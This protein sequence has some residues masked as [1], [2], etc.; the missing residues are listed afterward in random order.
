VSTSRPVAFPMAMMAGVLVAAILW[1]LPAPAVARGRLVQVPHATYTLPV[2]NGVWSFT[3]R[4]AHRN[5]LVPPLVLYDAHPANLDCSAI[6]FDYRVSQLAANEKAIGTVRLR[7]RCKHVPVGARISLR[8]RD[9]IVR[10]VPIR[11][12]TGRVAFSLDKPPGRVRPLV[13]LRAERIGGRC[14]TRGARLRIR[15]LRLDFA[16]GVTCER[17]TRRSTAVLMIGGLLRSSST[18]GTSLTR[19][20]AATPPVRATRE[21]VG[22]TPIDCGLGQ[23]VVTVTCS[24]SLDMW[25]WRS[26]SESFTFAGCP[27]GYHYTPGAYPGWLWSVVPDNGSWSV[28]DFAGDWWVTNWSWTHRTLNLT[29]YCGLSAP[30][31][32]TPPT[33]VG[34]AV[35]GRTLSCTNGTW[36]GYPNRFDDYEWTNGQGDEVALGQQYT[37]TSADYNGPLQCWVRAHNAVGSTP[38][39]SAYSPTVVNG[40]PY[41]I[42]DTSP[43]MD[44][45]DGSSYSLPVPG[46]GQPVHG[47]SWLLCSP[48]VWAETQNSASAITFQWL[49][50]GPGPANPPG[51]PISGATHSQYQVA[52]TQAG[53]QVRCQ[54][55]ASNQAGSTTAVSALSGIIHQEGPP[56]DAPPSTTAPGSAPPVTAPPST[57]VPGSSPN[58][59]SITGTVRN[60]KNGA[61][62]A[63]ASV[64]CGSGYSAT[65]ASNGS[66][67]IEQVESGT[68]ACTASASG[69]RSSTK[70]VTVPA[71]RTVTAHFRLARK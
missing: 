8:L 56:I 67:L 57:T 3:V 62:I 20:S 12:S 30:Q 24:Q 43:T 54:V 36:N 29:W 71:G 39:A 50:Y 13:S 14:R 51:S 65:T 58:L 53:S 38:A 17:V 60:S 32:I 21:A 48:G 11:R 35:V 4:L 22:D 23:G 68:Y 27:A 25:G 66:Y 61:K 16:S 40:P 70:S 31:L 49:Q 42:F 47:E 28:A 5:P 55:T 1:L 44:K 7:M 63:K 2:R 9:P 46:S 34:A 6:F 37:V 45:W 59:G 10:R 69:Y 33:I 26:I 64:K 19:R 18:H 15:R 52:N 41:L